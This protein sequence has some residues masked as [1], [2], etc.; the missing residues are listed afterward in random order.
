MIGRNE[1]QIVR[2]PKELADYLTPLP[3]FAVLRG[4]TPPEV[5]AIGKGLTA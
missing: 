3:L 5:G 4:I 2:N 1:L